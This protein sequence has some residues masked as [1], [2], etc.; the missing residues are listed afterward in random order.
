MRSGVFAED[1]SRGAV[2]E[3]VESVVDWMRD[4]VNGDTPA[5]SVRSAGDERRRET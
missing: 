2:E 4:Q 5:W 1:N 3:E